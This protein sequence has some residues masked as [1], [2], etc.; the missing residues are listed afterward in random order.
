MS[1]LA[2]LVSSA[3]ALVSSSIIMCIRISECSIRCIFISLTDR[4][5]ILTYAYFQD[6]SVDSLEKIFG[7][8][9]VNNRKKKCLLISVCILN[10]YHI[11]KRKC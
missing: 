10:N 11:C 1:A 3:A 6:I 2:F 4:T 9:A 7:K 5:H 8:T